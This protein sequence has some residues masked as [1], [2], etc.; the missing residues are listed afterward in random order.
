MSL[1]TDTLPTKE[2]VFKQGAW[3]AWPV[4]SLDVPYKAEQGSGIGNGEDR[5][6]SILGLQTMGQNSPYDIVMHDG[7]DGDIKQ[8]DK[9][10]SFN[11]GVRG[12]DVLRPIKEG[13]GRFLSDLQGIIEAGKDYFSEELKSTMQ[14]LLDKSPDEMCPPA[15]KSLDESFKELNIMRSTLG[16]SLIYQ[17]VSLPNGKKDKKRDDIWYNMLIASCYSDS[18]VC[19]EMG[20]QRFLQ[21]KL[22]N[23]LKHPYI[24]DAEK[25]M[26]ELRNLPRIF[27]NKWLFYVDEKKGFY[28]VFNAGCNV[29]FQRITKGS[30]RFVVK[31]SPEL[32]TK[33]EKEMSVAELKAECMRL[34]IKGYSNKNKPELR[35]LLNNH[36]LQGAS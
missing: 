4:E 11:S 29:E 7:N 27:D 28:P 3:N 24:I 30:P 2:Y 33:K 9:D 13:I 22:Y 21:A 25:M 36:P 19:N 14:S 6:S 17:E 8:L 1:T 26:H 15:L 10:G 5:L 16:E 35:E 32:Y 18:E 31:N 23:V 20:Q 12:R 34:G